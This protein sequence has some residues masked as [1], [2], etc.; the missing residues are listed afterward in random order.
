MLAITLSSLYNLHFSQ[1][2]ILSFDLLFCQFSLFAF[3]F[4]HLTYIL[5][6][7]ILLK[8]PFLLM[9]CVL[10]L[11][12]CRL[13]ALHKSWRTILMNFMHELRADIIFTICY[14]WKWYFVVSFFAMS[15]SLLILCL[16][17]LFCWCLCCLCYHH[18]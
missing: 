3:F 16:W 7:L 10:Y 18:M 14:M 12:I 17:T 4:L 13:K 8:S 11:S 15:W 1:F 5:F 6:S 2:G 9:E